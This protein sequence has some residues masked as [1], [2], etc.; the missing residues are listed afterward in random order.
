MSLKHLSSQ[1][2]RPLH[3][4]ILSQA[5]DVGPEGSFSALTP[6]LR[7][8]LYKNELTSLPPELGRLHNITV[9]SLRNNALTELPSFIGNLRRLKE[10]NIAGN[11]IEVLPW[12][13]LDLYNRGHTQSLRLTLRPNPLCQPLDTEVLA[14]KPA[15]D[16]RSIDQVR[17]MV[18]RLQVVLRDVACHGFPIYETML[19][20][21]ANGWLHHKRLHPDRPATPLRAASSDLSYFD[22]DGI[23]VRTLRQSFSDAPS[24][25]SHEPI[26]ADPSLPPASAISAPSLFELAARSCAGSPYHNQLSDL[27][28]C[29]APGTVVAAL[30]RALEAKER[31]L[32][33][34]SVC[35]KEYLVKRAEWIEYW[36]LHVGQEIIPARLVFTPFLRRACSWGCAL[37]AYDAPPE[38]CI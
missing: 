21:V 30:D 12:E 4:L 32:P 11:Q 18:E 7:I 3:Q 33:R 5:M 16:L 31:G 36:S 35:S 8:F 13:L 23:L 29:D 38:W 22:V 6:D 34:C 2:I 28:P 1:T 14:H 10:L 25:P 15:L 9:L 26:F 19:M 27:L 17:I 20:C 37:R 24:E